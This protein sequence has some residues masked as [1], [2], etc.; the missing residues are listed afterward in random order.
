MTNSEKNKSHSNNLFL[1]LTNIYLIFSFN[2]I[3]INKK[4]VYFYIRMT[5]SN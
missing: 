3:L 4:K 5:K 1:C 2:T